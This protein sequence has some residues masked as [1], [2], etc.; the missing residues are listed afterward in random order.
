[1]YIMLN[2]KIFV[3]LIFVAEY[4]RQKFFDSENFQIYGIMMVMCFLQGD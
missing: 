4:H 1:M 2:Y 3:Y